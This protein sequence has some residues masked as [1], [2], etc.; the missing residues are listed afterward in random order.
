[1]G[2]VAV[3][4]QRLDQ[5]GLLVERFTKRDIKGRA[6]VVAVVLVLAFGNVSSTLL[7]AP[8]LFENEKADD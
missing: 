1:M 3:G 2:K 6:V 4:D 5:A 7:Y 8:P